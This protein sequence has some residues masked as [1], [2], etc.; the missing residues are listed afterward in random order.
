MIMRLSNS[1]V[2]KQTCFTQ[3]VMIVTSESFFVTL[4]YWF[5]V[6][7]LFHSFLVLAVYIHCSDPLVLIFSSKS[8]SMLIII[9]VDIGLDAYDV[10]NVDMDVTFNIKNIDVYFY[11]DF[12]I[13]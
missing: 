11:V 1:A 13:N 12:K 3:K 8:T 2:C 10:D 6:V 5:N 7:F 9:N 4:N